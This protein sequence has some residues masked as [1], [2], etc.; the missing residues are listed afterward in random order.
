MPV[1]SA[2]RVVIAENVAHVGG[3]VDMANAAKILA[4]GAAGEALEGSAKTQ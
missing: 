2:E 1:E 4:A 3:A